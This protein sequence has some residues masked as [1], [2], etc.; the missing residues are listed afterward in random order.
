MFS[1]KSLCIRF[2][3]NRNVDYHYQNI[4]AELIEQIEW[5]RLI[6]TKPKFDNHSDIKF[7]CCYPYYSSEINCLYWIE[8]AIRLDKQEINIF[9]YIDPEDIDYCVYIENIRTTGMEQ[10]IIKN[11]FFIIAKLY[12]RAVFNYQD[13]MTPNGYKSVLNFLK[14]YFK[15]LSSDSIYRIKLINLYRKLS[16]K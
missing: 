2:I 11:S 3:L 9:D 12:L 10:N 15:T 1:L 13:V 8:T 7:F 5:A 16:N 4:P 6:R 14:S